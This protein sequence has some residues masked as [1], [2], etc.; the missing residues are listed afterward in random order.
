MST[1]TKKMSVVQLTILTFIN[2]AGSGIIML[3][4]KLAQVGTISVLSWLITAAGSLALAYVFAKCGRF[5]KRDGGMNG[6]ASYAFGKSG[7]FM[8]GWTYGL[9]LLIANIAIAI[10]CVGYGSAF[11]EVTL[12]PVETCLYT[13][14]ILWICTFANFGGAKIT[15][16]IGTFTVWGVILPVCSLGIV[17][18]FW[19]NPTMYIEAWNPHSLPFGEAVSA[20]IA[21]T[22][23]AFL[24]LESACA[25]SEAVENPEKNVPI[26]VLGGTL[27]AAVVYIVSTNIC[28]GIVAN[29][30]LAASTAPF[31][32]VWTVMLGSAAGKVVAGMAVLACAGSLL[33]WQFTIA[34]VFKSSSDA[35]FFPKL[36]SQVDKRGTPIKGMIAITIIQSVLSLMTISP[37]LNEQFEA[38]VNLAVVTNVIPYILCMG[39]I[40]IMQQVAHVPEREMKTTN[41]IALIGSLY[42]FYALYGSGYEAMMWGSIV[43]FLGWSAYGLIAAKHEPLAN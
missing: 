25:N 32:T 10:T 40:F 37:T 34:S 8:A 18:W 9:S 2:M 19:F 31:S 33:G 41:I 23:W 3:P 28:S 1:E 20:S 14:A 7:A 29:S 38:L 12:S 26:A 4:S 11:F 43:T 35:G 27:I 5:S 36:F 30:E 15:G 13:I 24:G 22:L 16:Q 6:Y 21:M 39:A 17:G 42:S